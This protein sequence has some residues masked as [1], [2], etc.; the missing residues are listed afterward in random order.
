MEKSFITFF[1]TPLHNAACEGHIECV[2][3]LLNAGADVNAK[4]VRLK[5][6]IF[7]E[8]EVIRSRRIQNRKRREREKG[9]R[10]G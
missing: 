5:I 8:R 10:R 4:M 3:S 6:E 9:E 2:W 7:R 1:K